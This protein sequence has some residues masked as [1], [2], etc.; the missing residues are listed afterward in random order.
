M[1]QFENLKIG[2]K[3]TMDFE[4]TL[5]FLAIILTTNSYILNSFFE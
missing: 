4:L 5:K 2:L 3:P 1:R